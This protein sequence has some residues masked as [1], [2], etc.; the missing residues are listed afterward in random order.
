MNKYEENSTKNIVDTL[1][2]YEEK[3]NNVDTL[4]NRAYVAIDRNTRHHL[5]V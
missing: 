3:I 1:H 4:P 5:K 2:K